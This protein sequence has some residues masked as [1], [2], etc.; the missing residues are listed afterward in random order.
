[1]TG[2]TSRETATSMR[3]TPTQRR[4]RERVRQILEASAELL[5]AGGYEA[6]TTSAIAEHAEIS[7]A[8]IYQFFPNVDSIVATLAEQ[9]T[10][11]FYG[12]LDGV[13]TGGPS[14]TPGEASDRI[15]DAY[16]AYFRERRGFRAVWFGGALRGAA[17]RLD[18]RSNEVLAE[19]LLGLWARWYGVP[20]RPEA[21]PAARTA[22]A[23]A[24]ALL[25]MA[26]RED[27]DG[28]P[29]LITETKRAVRAYTADAVAALT[30]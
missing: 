4:S 27:R 25:A 7:V 16:V 15:I 20:E 10:E 28:D 3:R 18:R 17:R 9:W 6:L 29:V 26:F 13:E 14:P 22:V 23:I 30:A 24:D 8:S 5:E 1:M 12:V 11:G 2:N 19:R 21:L